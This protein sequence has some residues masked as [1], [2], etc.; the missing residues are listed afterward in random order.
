MN[1]YFFWYG[2][3]HSVL[4]KGLLTAEIALITLSATGTSTQG[5]YTIKCI[6]CNGLT[7]GKKRTVPEIC[8]ILIKV[9][10]IYIYSMVPR[11][12]E[13][14]HCAHFF[15]YP[16]K[17]ISFPSPNHWSSAGRSKQSPEPQR[18]HLLALYSSTRTSKER[19]IV[20]F[21]RLPMPVSQLISKKSQ[22]DM[23][24][25]SKQTTKRT[26]ALLELFVTHLKCERLQWTGFAI[27]KP[28]LTIATLALH[29]DH[30]NDCKVVPASTTFN[31]QMLQPADINRTLYKL[32]AEYLWSNIT[33]K[34]CN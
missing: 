6:G 17:M 31:K 18:N 13:P 23:L 8:F 2:F 3:T 24:L 4:D 9:G 29:S 27:A 12:L 7:T 20:P 19:G 26:V 15:S 1:E 14:I 34:I 30:I 28:E 21:R 33:H 32:A 5:Q 10:Y 11:P 22:H 25:D 16:A